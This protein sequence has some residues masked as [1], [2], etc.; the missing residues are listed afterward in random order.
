[1]KL[2]VV[3]TGMI[4][5]LLGAHLIEWGCDVA[6]I[7][8]TPN[9]M[10]RVNELVGKIGSEGCKGWPDYAEMLASTTPEEVDTIYVA[11]PNFLHYSFCKQALEAGRNVIVEKPMCSNAREADELAALARE[12]QAFFFEAITTLYQ[13]TYKKIGELLPRVGTVKLVSVNYSQYSSRYNAFREGTVLP[14]FD[15]AKSGGAL[16][17]LGLYC[18]QWICGLFGEPQQ[19]TYLANVERGIDTSGVTTLDYGEFKAVSVAAKDC[20][21]PCQ[22]LIEG[23]DGY[24]LQVT[25]PNNCG[26]VELHLNDGTVERYDLNPELQWESEFRAFVSMMGAGDL[27]GCY[28]MLDQSL[29]VSRVQTEVRKSAGVIFPADEA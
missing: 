6:A 28:R 8:G 25:P 26:P 1:M 5:D 18:L 13:P 2:A 17:D 27:G 23:T 3:G 16:M 22:T 12:R 11:V 7:V 15:P 24:I 21:A 14:A 20:A 9:T 29:L 19:V 10:D 4:V